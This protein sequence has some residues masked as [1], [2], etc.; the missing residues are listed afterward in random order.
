M[1]FAFEEGGQAWDRSAFLRSS[2]TN[3]ARPQQIRR[4]GTWDPSYRSRTV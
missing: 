3:L 1:R 4:Q 2:S